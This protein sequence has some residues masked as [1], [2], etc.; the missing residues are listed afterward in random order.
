MKTNALSLSVWLFYV[1]TITV[2]AMI[3]PNSIA[4]AA[5]ALLGITLLVLIGPPV[6]SEKWD[7]DN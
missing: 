5:A 6:W 3:G 2:L 4:F 1:F 7:P